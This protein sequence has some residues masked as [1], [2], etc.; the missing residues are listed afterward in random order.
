MRL[1][2]KNNPILYTVCKRSFTIDKK[3]IDKMFDLMYRRG[4]LGLAAPQVGIDAALFVTSWGEVFINPKVEHQGGSIILGEG[5][6]SLPGLNVEKERFEHVRVNGK[7]YEGWSA[8]VIQHEI[9]HLNGI[10]IDEPEVAPEARALLR[11]LKRNKTPFAYCVSPQN[12]LRISLGGQEFFFPW[13]N[14]MESNR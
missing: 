10:L 2:S 1:V 14:E 13:S 7:G 8:R 4:G 11:Q 3:Q 6:L 12:E 5:C 9:D